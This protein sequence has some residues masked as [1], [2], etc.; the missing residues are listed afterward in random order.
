MHT[1]LQLAGEWKNLRRA[2]KKLDI[3]NEGCVSLSDFKAILKN[4]DV[5]L[6]EDEVF[7]VMSH[8]DQNMT[9]KVSYTHFLNETISPKWRG[10]YAM[11][12][13]SHFWEMQMVFSRGGSRIFQTGGGGQLIIWLNFSNKKCFSALCCASVTRGFC[14]VWSERLDA[15][16]FFIEV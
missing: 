3:N 11:R 13:S 9:G 1:Y 12:K 5:T 8:F 16:D 10:S 4:A 14:C 6:D 2:F 7:H 15:D